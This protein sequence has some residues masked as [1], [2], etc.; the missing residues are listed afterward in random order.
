MGVIYKGTLPTPENDGSES[1]GDWR[2]YYN[3]LYGT[4]Y[5][6]LEPWVLQGFVNKPTW[7]EAEYANDD[8]L[9]YGD[10][11]WKYLHRTVLEG[12]SEVN[13]TTFGNDG[14]F[15]PGDGV[16][17]TAYAPGDIITLEDDD[18]I[19]AAIVTVKSVDSEH[20]FKG[21]QPWEVT[22]MAC[23]QTAVSRSIGVSQPCRVS[24]IPPARPLAVTNR[25]RPKLLNIAI[26]FTGNSGQSLVP[27]Y[28]FP[29]TF[30]PFTNSL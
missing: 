13:Y 8:I 14:D 30:S 15:V 29:F 12:Q 9:L 5:P 6:H 11:R 3:K 7:W 17:P 24:T 4:P 28:P 25:I 16:G 22:D 23:A 27:A 21:F 10:R 1:G 20:G 18:S 19:V 26:H 2:D